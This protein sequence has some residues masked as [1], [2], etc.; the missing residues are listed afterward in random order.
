[1]SY[2]AVFFDA[3]ETLLHP[4]PTFAER[5]AM[6]VAQDG[7]TVD[8]AAVGEHLHVVFDHFADAARQATLWTT[9]PERSR[10]FWLS[11]YGTVLERLRLSVDGRPERLFEAFTDLDAYALFPDVPDALEALAGRGY[12]L[13]LISNFEPWLAD[14]LAHLGIA[15][16]FAVTVISGVVGVEKPD[17]AIFRLALERAGVPAGEAAYVGD[18]PVLDTEPAAALGMGAVL[19]DRRRRFPDHS[20][21]R[22]E[23]LAELPAA[24]G[25]EPAS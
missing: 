21:P 16:R 14:L 5:F 17:P 10:A 22:I 19:L 18:N 25:L 6:V 24:L 9:D 1:M 15:D 11:V 2:H 13:G 4:E 23:T 20:G 7:A 8:A 3:G 12:V